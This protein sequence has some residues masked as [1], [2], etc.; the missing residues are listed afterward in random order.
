M[1]IKIDKLIK[2]KRK[3]VA[4]EINENAQLIVRAPW[5]LSQAR[6]NLIL[7]EKIDWIKNKQREILKK[8]KLSRKNFIT[9][10]KFLYLGK[11]YELKFAKTPK[12][13]DLKDYFYLSNRF[14]K[15]AEAVFRYWYKEMAL[16]K[17]RERTLYYANK[18]DFKINKIK[19]SSARKRWGSCSS[20]GNLNFSWRLIMAP[21]FVLDYVIVHEL[22][23]LKHMDH[24]KRFWNKVAEIYPNYLDAKNWLTDNGHLLNF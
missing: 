18:Y 8:V 10:E 17:F 3:T 1:K 13:I 19:L 20:Q 24:S 22:V 4:L 15:S 11:E 9:G 5:R 12:A 23:H 14:E 6:L 2:S 7:Q 21:L 16:E